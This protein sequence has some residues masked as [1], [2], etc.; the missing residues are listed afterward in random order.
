M[1]GFGFDAAIDGAASIALAWRFATE[2]R[3]PHRTDSVERAAELIVGCVLLILAA[4]LGFN[5]V[6]ALI[7]DAHPEVT[8][9]GIAI[10]L[11]SVVIL[12][13]LAIAKRRTANGLGSGALRADSV[14][15]MIAAVLALISLVGL[16]LTQLFGL[17][18]AD[19]I[20]ALI[21]TAVLLREGWFS[22]RAAPI[23]DTAPSPEESA[24]PG[25]D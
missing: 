14:L 15:T 5:A 9:V 2:T 3:Y 25:L 17:Y 12:P 11:V 6:T 13:P 16:A 20:G 19:A 23:E 22:I 7:N 18:S 10:S 21:V 4:Y 24:E 1:L 8:P